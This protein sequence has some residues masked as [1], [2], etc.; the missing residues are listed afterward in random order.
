MAKTKKPSADDAGEL[1]VS[2][3]V[4]TRTRDSVSLIVLFHNARS[5]PSCRS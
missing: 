4:Y 2:V 1:M 3:E 5:H